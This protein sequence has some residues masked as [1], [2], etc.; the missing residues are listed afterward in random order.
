MNKSKWVMIDDKIINSELVS[1][2]TI[3]HSQQSCWQFLVTTVIIRVK[4]AGSYTDFYV[5]KCRS[6]G[7]TLDKELENKAS[8]KQREIMEKLGIQIEG[9]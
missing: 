3:E 8:A 7:T 2:I 9:V 4:H 5:G 6:H 1:S